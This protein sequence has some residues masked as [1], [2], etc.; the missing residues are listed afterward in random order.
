MDVDCRLYLPGAILG[1]V[2][3]SRP[4]RQENNRQGASVSMDLS[5]ASS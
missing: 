2:N 3:V 5:A 4:N 1:D